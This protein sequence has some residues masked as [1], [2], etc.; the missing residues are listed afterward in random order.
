MKAEAANVEAKEEV[1][2]GTGDGAERGL[3]EDGAPVVEEKEEEE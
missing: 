3:V 2:G 1:H